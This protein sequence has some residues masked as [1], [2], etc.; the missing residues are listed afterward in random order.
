M[1]LFIIL[2]GF[3]LRL[4]NLDQSLWLDEAINI[5]FVKS[6][7]FKELI[8][9][10]SLSDLPPPLF[11]VLLKSWISLFGSSEIAIRFP[12]I[13]FGV[14]TVFITYLIGKKLF[15]TKTALIAST[16]IATA[17]LH[18]Y[19]SQEARMY[20]MAAFL[21]SLSC[22]FFITILEKDSLISW[23]GFVT[24]TTLMLYSDYL[25]YVL[26]PLFVF[27]LFINRRNITKGT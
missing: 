22:Y 18:I 9:N 3:L 26:I 25:P 21:A 23:F 20:M 16:L 15:E 24:S 27:Y 1:I 17:P 13:I 8:L 10:Y 14:G 4:V 7:S 11:H 12:S 2:I 19:Y 6:L 5:N